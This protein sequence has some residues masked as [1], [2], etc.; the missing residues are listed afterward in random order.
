MTRVRRLPKDPG[1]AGWAEL[2]PEEPPHPSLET[3]RTADWLV[4]GAGFAGLAAARR[5]TQLRPSD[6]VVL[7]EASRVGQG[8]AGRN[9]GFMIDLPHDLTSDDYSGRLEHDR[10]QIKQNRAAIAFAGEAAKEYGLEGEAFDRC[11]KI[12]GAATA[13]GYV[14]NQ[15]FARHLAA[16]NE[17][18]ELL[19]ADQMRDVTGTD[20]YR[21]GLYS[22]GTVILQPA[23]YV[24]GVARGLANKIALHEL[25]P[26]TSLDRSGADWCARTPGGTVTAPRVILAVNGHAESFGYFQRRLMHVFTYASMTRVLTADEIRRL[27]GRSRWNLTPA[28][29]MGTTVRRISGTGGDRIVVRNRFTYDPSME[30][31]DGR[32]H[33]IAQDHDASYRARFPMLADVE[34]EYRW[35]GRLCLSMNGVQAFGEVEDGVFAACCQ[36]GLGVAKGTLAGMCA[37][38]LAAQGNA[39]LVDDLLAAP[40]PSR[41]PPEP[42]ATIGANVVLRWK[43][44]RAGAEL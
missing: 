13:K 29:P 6:S 41:L 20:F 42:L 44:W 36:N 32:M 10:V 17:R 21:N 30:V 23:L 9:S 28:D 7:L 39:D 25:S 27:G 1:P 2:L 22:P 11:G 38:D 33:R 14:H 4:I 31:D 19:D 40:P 37:A 18:C 12:N 35:G 26:V 34:M 24:R 5:L 15:D 3:D 16:L 43:E 8:P